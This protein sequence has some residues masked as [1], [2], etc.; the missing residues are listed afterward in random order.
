MNHEKFRP[1]RSEE[2]PGVLVIED[3]DHDYDMLDWAIHKSKI[4]CQLHHYE[5][6]DEALAFLQEHLDSP[7]SL[8]RN[9][10]LALVLLDLNLPGVDGRTVLERIKTHP[11]LK[12]LPVVIFSTS[13]N[14][15]DIAACYANGANAYVKKP[16]DIALLQ[17]S[18]RALLNHWLEINVSYFQ[19]LDQTQPQQPNSTAATPRP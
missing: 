1:L 8:L 14:P 12:V 11:V 4:P 17:E 16:M 2:A 18:V 3:S 6:G 7:H 5:T 9:L 13:T 19:I 15:K 10:K